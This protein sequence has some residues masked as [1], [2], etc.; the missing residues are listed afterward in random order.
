M[1]FTKPFEKAFNDLPPELRIGFVKDIEN[2]I[3]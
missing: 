3:E 2:N 1:F